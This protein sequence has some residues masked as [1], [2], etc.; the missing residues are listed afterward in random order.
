MKRRR[1]PY[2]KTVGCNTEDLG[3]FD[4]DG[5]NPMH[6]Q[7]VIKDFIN[8]GGYKVNLAEVEQADR[9]LPRRSKASAR[10]GRWASHGSTGESGRRHRGEIAAEARASTSRPSKSTAW[11]RRESSRCKRALLALIEQIP[12]KRHSARRN[13]KSWPSEVSH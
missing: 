7:G 10:Q 9:R 2:F 1:R 11:R 12:R 8:V 3:R 13:A 6:H 5:S 4:E